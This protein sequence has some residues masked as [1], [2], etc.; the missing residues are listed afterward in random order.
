MKST[1]GLVF[2]LALVLSACAPQ[3]LAPEAT[4]IVYSPTMLQNLATATPTPVPV[5]WPNLKSGWSVFKS[6]DYISNNVVYDPKGYIWAA[7]GGKT[8][9]RWDLSSGEAVAFKAPDSLGGIVQDLAFYADTVW[10]TGGNGHVAHLVGNQW[11]VEAV[12]NSAV[13]KF[14]VTPGRLWLS[15]PDVV[16]YSDGKEWKAFNTIPEEFLGNHAGS[17][18]IAASQDGSFWLWFSASGLVVR[19]DGAR[20]QDYPGLLSP[21]A[22][23]SLNDGSVVVVGPG[24]V[25]RFDGKT[26]S[27]AAFPG[28]SDFSANT[29]LLTP[30]GDLWLDRYGPAS[31]SYKGLQDYILQTYILHDGDVRQQPDLTFDQAPSQM[32]STR[33][34]A[35]TPSGLVFSTDHQLYLYA[36]QKW[37]EYVP[38]GHTLIQDIV[39]G[40]P[41]GFSADGRL[42]VTPF[43][44]PLYFDGK[45]IG[46]TS[47][48]IPCTLPGGNYDYT[49]WFIAPPDRIWLLSAGY[50]QSGLCRY[51]IDTGESSATDLFFLPSDLVYAPDGTLWASSDAGFIVRLNE[52]YLKSG[53]YRDLKLIKVGEGLV[54]Y[55]LKPSRLIAGRDGSIWVFVENS[56]LYRYDGK[57]WKYYGLS[58]LQDASALAIS[59]DGTVWAGFAGE[60]MHYDGEKWT[61][62]GHACVTPS[63]IVVARDGAVWFKN[64]CDGVYRF[65]G[66]TWTHFE[67]DKYLGGIV[68]DQIMVAPDGALWFFSYN[69]WARYKQ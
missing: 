9:M 2:T 27:D 8:I 53:D 37:Q 40:S 5:P 68:P 7:V 69:G 18:S 32:T 36:A 48:K 60:L 51:D 3:G 43:N 46:A 42:W 25:S 12:G 10:I 34:V 26:L 61:A 29:A 19:F 56:G 31:S 4:P 14:S 30:D 6:P 65:D 24:K 16:Y 22:M 55:I 50:G 20:W 38:A 67:K 59:P 39:S 13:Y 47:E 41:I 54:D 57:S 17:I 66:A 62:Y 11:Y 64:G 28:A 49:Q 23:F 21:Q 1:V 44:Q 15:G 35:M 58:S 45:E 52:D 63:D 33:P